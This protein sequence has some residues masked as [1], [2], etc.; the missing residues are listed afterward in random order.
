MAYYKKS[1]KKA[2]TEPVEYVPTVLDNPSI[3]QMNI[4]NAVISKI[5]N[6][7]LRARA[8]TGKT[9]T[10]M[11][12]LQFIVGTCIYVCFNKRNAEE[13]K[14]KVPP[15]VNA[16]TLHSLGFKILFTALGKIKCVKRGSDKTYFILENHFPNVPKSAYS[17]IHKAVAMCKNSLTIERDTIE[18]TVMEYDLS[19]EENGFTSFDFITAIEG[20]IEYGKK[21]TSLI[22]FEDML[23]L[24]VILNLSFPH[25]ENVLGDEAQD[26]TNLQMEFIWRLAEPDGRIIIVGDDRQSIYGFAGA[27]KS[28]LNVFTE[29]L[30]AI[31]FPLTLTY[32]CPK[33]IVALAS[34]EVGDYEAAPGNPEGSITEA[35]CGEIIDMAQEGDLILSRK[36]AP[37]VNLS[38]KFL[39]EKKRA[40]VL[41][42][43]FGDALMAIVRKY[44]G[45][46]LDGFKAHLIKWEEKQ[47]KALTNKFGE[48]A[49]FAG[50]ED[51]IQCLFIFVLES[52]NYDE[53]ISSIEN[54]FSDLANDSTCITLSSVHK[55]KGLEYD[56]VFML[57]DTFSRSGDEEER[58]LWYVA[59][60]RTKKN[61]ILVNGLPNKKEEE[62]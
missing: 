14:C 51:K 13:A 11:W 19:Y 37:I 10:L 33:A 36:N 20:V 30:K 43:D 59:V 53:L 25:Y 57:N 39:A 38:Y 32:R 21:L 22:D 5:G 26:F 24:P 8:G 58:N 23:F 3:Q 7:C 61:L 48:N 55:A 18:N 60:T 47:K 42:K 46:D 52:H 31:I 62:E 17:A 40:K 29:R 35:N 44:K 50:I 34:E 28:A 12:L 45:H 9:T 15:N 4:K 49:N 6:L 56:N 1:Y 27:K 16:T 2:P 54:L 41:G